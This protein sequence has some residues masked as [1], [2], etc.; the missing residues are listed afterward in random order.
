MKRLAAVVCL[1]PLLLAACGKSGNGG[2]SL[3]PTRLGP[4]APGNDAGS[5]HFPAY[6]KSVFDLIA[7]TYQGQCNGNAGS[8]LTA[9]LTITP[10]GVMSSDQWKADLAVNVRTLTLTRQFGADAAPTA[11]FSA[12]GTARPWKLI[13]NSEQGGRVMFGEADDLR[14]CVRVSQAAAL[15][16]KP[17][18]PPVAALLQRAAGDVGCIVEGRLQP[19]AFKPEADGVMM[20][21]IR[22]NFGGTLTREALIVD[23]Q[24]GSLQ[25]DAN[26][27]DGGRLTLTLDGD[28]KLQ[29]ATGTAPNGKPVRCAPPRG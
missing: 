19:R 16:S 27:A 13:I 6:Q 2:Y 23:A 29:S 26:Y 3:A 20:D 7:A 4:A 10:A 14:Y 5:G 11:S 8:T 28:G 15:A 21:Q 1:L 12:D 22:F 25:Y 18:Y 17:L 9:A 24:T